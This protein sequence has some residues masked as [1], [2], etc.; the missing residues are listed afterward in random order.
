MEVEAL[1]RCPWLCATPDG[2]DTPFEW[3]V[4]LVV[5]LLRLLIT[6][7][8]LVLIAVSVWAIRRSTT[9]GQ[10]IR[11]LAVIALLVSI[12]GTELGHL[13]DAPHWRFLVNL[14]GIVL[15]AW[16]YYQ[17]L[18]REMPARDRHVRQ[19]PSP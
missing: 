7:G 13:G 2:P 17:H 4:Y 16:G 19:D 10:K 3:P 18:F 12:I 1:D 11:F 9:A 5:D 8:A 6:A 15:M 14:T